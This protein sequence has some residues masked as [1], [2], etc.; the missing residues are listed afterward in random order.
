[1]PV[2]K[3]DGADLDVVHVGEGRDLVLLHTLLSDRSV[4]DR[5]VPALAKRRRVW[6]P[7]LPG[8]G[9]STPVGPRLEEYADRVAAMFTALGLSP[10]TDV[11]S[12]GFGGHVAI[13][14]A[15]R[16]G[17]RFRRLVIADSVARFSDPGREALHVMAER[18]RAMGIAAA[19]EVSIRRTF[20]DAFIAKHPDVVDDRRRRIET[21]DPGAFRNACL[22]LAAMD[23]RAAL[24]GMRNPTLVMTGALDPTTPPALGRELAAGIPGARFMEIPDCAHCPPIETPDLFVATVE[25][26][27]SGNGPRS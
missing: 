24:G 21:F 18:V 27:L 19:V 15:V 4:Y 14:L 26:F 9:A 25:E 3:V 6:L 22:A 5:A 1:M 2:M 13:A 8:F 16:H 7:N 17:A 12:N 23:F 10:E 20:T 11:A